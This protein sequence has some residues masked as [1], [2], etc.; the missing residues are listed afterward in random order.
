MGGGTYKGVVAV[1]GVDVD[2][3]LA[4]GSDLAEPS[5]GVGVLV[6]CVADSA[7]DANTDFLGLSG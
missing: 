7:G 6:G 5:D 1:C 3:A 2:V 4:V